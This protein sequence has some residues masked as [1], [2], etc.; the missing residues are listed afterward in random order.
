M[1]DSCFENGPWHCPFLVA[2]CKEGR[3]ASSIIVCCDSRTDGYSLIC[4]YWVPL[5]ARR[6]FLCNL[7][8]DN[9]PPGQHGGQSGF[10]S[11][12]HLSFARP[13]AVAAAESTRVILYYRRRRKEEKGSSSSSF[14]KSVSPLPH[15]HPRSLDGRKKGGRDV[16]VVKRQKGSDLRRAPSAS[17]FR[18]DGSSPSSSSAATAATKSYLG[19]AC[20]AAPPALPHSCERSNKVE[21]ASHWMSTIQ[22]STGST[23]TSAAHF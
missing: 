5:P 12:R 11:A 19:S 2:C 18:P 10:V 1:D 9:C 17:S 7:W 20:P 21:V 15:P 23:D 6:A 8:I 3:S 14:P 16:I 13:A 4:D 22:H